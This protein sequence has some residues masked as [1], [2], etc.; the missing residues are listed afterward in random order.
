MERM[1][2]VLRNSE[3]R[4]YSSFDTQAFGGNKKDYYQKITAIEGV[5]GCKILRA[6]DG[7]AHNL[8][9]H[10]LAIIT[11]SE[12]GQASQTLVTNVQKL[13]DPK[14]DQL[15]DGLASIGHTCHIQSVKTKSINIDTNIVYDS[16]YNFNAL[17]SH[18]QNAIDSYFLEL[19][20]S[21]DTVDGIV[22]RI[23]NI[24]SKILAINGIKD[25]ADT[26][27][28]GTASNAILD[29]DTIAVRGAFN[30]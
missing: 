15:G 11:N 14:G 4:Y 19:N 21:W 29:P 27:L 26:K 7:N 28:N 23:S 1:K 10:I 25:I 8:P 12:Y 16:G 20:K 17:K 30:G 9:G 18:I 13:I 2:K 3:K 24:E 22:V 6:K 5:G